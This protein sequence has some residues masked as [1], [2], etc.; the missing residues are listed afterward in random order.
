[1]ESLFRNTVDTVEYE[2]HINQ[3]VWLPVIST[4]LL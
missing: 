1:V 2:T 4:V 3:K